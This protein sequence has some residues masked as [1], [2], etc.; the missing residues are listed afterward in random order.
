V[1]LKRLD[2]ID[3]IA[4]FSGN[5]VNGE[6]QMATKKAKTFTLTV[7]L[8][9]LGMMGD[10]DNLVFED[11]LPY[12]K[13]VFVFN[14]KQRRKVMATLQQDGIQLPELPNGELDD[15]DLDKGIRI[16]AKG[17]KDLPCWPDSEIVTDSEGNLSFNHN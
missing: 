12:Q 7:T 9:D 4:R 5:E 6:K 2:K 3:R 15:S 17:A 1:C 8:H 11:Q 14:E 10:L 16:K 13:V